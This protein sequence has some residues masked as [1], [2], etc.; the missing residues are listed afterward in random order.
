M[1]LSD[2]RTRICYESKLRVLRVPIGL[3]LSG[4]FTYHLPTE[5]YTLSAGLEPALPL[6]I[7]RLGYGIHLPFMTTRTNCVVRVE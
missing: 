6:L 5:R 3:L 2:S 7:S 1:L 4:I